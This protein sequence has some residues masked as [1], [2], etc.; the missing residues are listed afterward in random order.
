MFIAGLQK[1]SLLDFPGKLCA[2]VFTA[3]CNLR[4]PFCHNA[5]LVTRVNEAE[6]ISEEEFFAFLNK[7]VGLL[8]GICVTGGEPLLQPDIT[9]FIEKIRA[10]GFAVKL[11]TNGAFP[12]KLEALL[13]AGLIDYAAM[14]I[15]NCKAKYGE[16]VGKEVFDITPIEKNVELLKSSGIPHEFRTT[17]VREFHT[18]QNIAEIAEWIAPSRYFLQAFKDSGDLICGELHGFS[19]EEIQNFASAAKKFLDHVEIRGE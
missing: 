19:K 17:V 12:E 5:S 9:D 16:T 3:G 15:K 10:L 18:A 7:R 4:C 1:L 14:D 11:D 8:D 13:S 2:T 6:Q